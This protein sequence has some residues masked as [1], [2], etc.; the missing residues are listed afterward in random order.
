MI[1]GLRG[2]KK[3]TY[4]RR[5]SIALIDLPTTLQSCLPLPPLAL[6][7]QLELELELRLEQGQSYCGSMSRNH[8]RSW[9]RLLTRE[10]RGSTYRTN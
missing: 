6:I 9:R 2:M 3:A 1:S 10:M 5:R 8:R 4:E 7:L